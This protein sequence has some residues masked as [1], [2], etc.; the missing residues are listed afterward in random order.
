MLSTQRARKQDSATGEYL[1][2]Q[3]ALPGTQIE[4]IG[5]LLL[6]SDSD[7]LHSRFRRDFEAFAGDEAYWFEN[8]ADEVSAKSRE[9][10]GQ[11][12][13][14]WMEETLSHAVRVSPRCSVPVNNY[15][16]TAEWLYAKYIRPNDSTSDG[17]IARKA[18][19]C[20]V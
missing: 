8:L 18:M 2:V 19:L 3:A 17:L 12:C 10:G 20:S 4:N 13:V 14:E 15:Y 1:L 9:L 6:D 16:Q 7:W 5:I 11:K